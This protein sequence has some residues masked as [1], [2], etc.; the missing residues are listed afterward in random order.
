MNT[1]KSGSLTPCVFT[2][3]PA[4]GKD[5][6]CAPQKR[7]KPPSHNMQ[8]SEN[9]AEGDLGEATTGIGGSRKA[10]QSL[11]TLHSRSVSITS[12]STQKS[13]LT[14]L[15]TATAL[16]GTMPYSPLGQHPFP[17]LTKL[18]ANSD[19]CRASSSSNRGRTISYRAAGCPSLFVWV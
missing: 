11:C 14:S 1:T 8:S 19:Y 3:C 16:Q 9:R 10:S 6:V 7:V 12:M 15:V 13:R 17:S 4:L 18:L 5:R 2:A